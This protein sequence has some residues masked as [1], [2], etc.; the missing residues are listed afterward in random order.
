MHM[1]FFSSGVELSVCEQWPVD[2]N[3]VDGNGS[4]RTTASVFAE[5][6]RLLPSSP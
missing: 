4:M 1:R 3:A 2:S 5:C 6:A